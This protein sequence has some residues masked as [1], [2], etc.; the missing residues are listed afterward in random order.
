[1]AQRHGLFRDTE[2][3]HNAIEAYNK[4]AIDHNMTCSQL[5]LAWCN[6]FDWVTSTIIGATKMTQL[7]ENIEAFDIELSKEAMDEINKVIREYPMPF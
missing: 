3:T 7:K 6:S 4:I 5:S 2:H 1:M